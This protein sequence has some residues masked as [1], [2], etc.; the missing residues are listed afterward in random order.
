M[1]E[2]D[3]MHH[4][5]HSE[6]AAWDRQTDRQTDENAALLNA[7]CGRRQGHNNIHS[8]CRS[9][10]HRDA[11]VATLLRLIFSS[12]SSVDDCCGAIMRLSSNGGAWPRLLASCGPR[13]GFTARWYARPRVKEP[14]GSFT[15]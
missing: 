6:L 15:A 9:A 7:A 13:S 5:E 14:I 3:E 4:S 1:N 2:V 8:V 12:H 10:P 11:S